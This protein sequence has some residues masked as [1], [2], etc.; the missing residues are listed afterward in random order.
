MMKATATL[1]SSVVLVSTVVA[2]IVYFSIGDSLQTTST[3]A[4]WAPQLT[5]MLCLALRL[6]IDLD[7]WDFMSRIHLLFFLHITFVIVFPVRPYIQK[8]SS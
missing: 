5:V 2:I 8:R 7:V 6:L 4:F 1:E 3:V